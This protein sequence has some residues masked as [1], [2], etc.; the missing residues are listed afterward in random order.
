MVASQSF[1]GSL[2]SYISRPVAWRG[3]GK[4]VS[5]I[6][7]SVGFSLVA[8]FATG[9]VFFCGYHD[10]AG[11]LHAARYTCRAVVHL[12]LVVGGCFL[13]FSYVCFIFIACGDVV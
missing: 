12:E 9:I 6:P 5:C 13:G 3:A 1:G 10:T 7:R 11:V 2:R 4:E 8:S